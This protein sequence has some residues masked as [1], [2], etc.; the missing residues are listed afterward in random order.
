MKKIQCGGVHCAHVIT[1]A[2][3]AIANLI[4]KARCLRA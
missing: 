3:L 1:A 4:L 2:T